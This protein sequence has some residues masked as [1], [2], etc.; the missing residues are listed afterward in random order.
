MRSTLKWVAIGVGGIVAVFALVIAYVAA[1]F[2]PNEYKADIEKT[3]R[4]KTGRTL[5]IKGDIG[6]SIFPSLGMKLGQTS[7]SE[8]NSE[9]EFASVSSAVVSVK[10]LPLLS[11]EVIVDAVQV[12][13]L[14]AAITHDKAGAFNFG[15]LADTKEK[16]EGEADEAMKI[17]IAKIEIVDADVTFADQ[18]AGTR[19][20]LSKL[21]LETGRVANGVTTP[22]DLSATVA[23]DK[24]KAQLDTKLKSK[25][26][27]DVDKKLYR[28]ADLDAS[29]KGNYGGISGMTATAKGN[30]EARLAT[31]EYAADALV[32]NVTG[33]QAG[34][35]MS[36][37]LDAPKLILTQ[38]KVDGGKI[39]AEVKLQE[40]KSRTTAKIT[41]GRVHG[42]FKAFTAGPLDADIEIEGD[43]RTTKAKLA[44]GLSGDLEAKRFELP[45]LSL[46]A[47]VTD[48]K[49]PRGSFDATITGIARADLTKQTG[50]LDF[51][52]KIEQS[53][54][55]GRLGITDFSPLAVTFDLNADELDVDRLLGKTRGKDGKP[56]KDKPAATA[57]KDDKIDLSAL[58]NVNAAGSVKVGKLT[59][60]NLKGSQVRAG[61]KV[62]G[63]RLDVAPLSAQLYQGT[64]N[65]SLSASAADN[66]V[67]AVKQTLAGVSVGPLL[68]DA[69]DIDTLEGKGTVSLDLTTQGATMDALK[70]ALGG[71]ASVNLADGAIK[72]IDI[73]GTIRGARDKVRELRGQQVKASDKTQKTDFSELKASFNVKNGVA[74]NDDL[75]MKSPL[76]RVSGAGDIDIGNDRLNY[77]LK[78]TL[79]ATTQGQGGRD[80]TDLTGLTIPVKLTG[81]LE[82]PD[83]TIDF[84][85]MVTD[86]A[87]Q[88][89]QDEI[90]KRLPGQTKA[91]AAPA[92]G[93]PASSD[94]RDAI[95][96]RLKGILGR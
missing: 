15:D 60:L 69:A 13:G 76:L 38:Q 74:R 37:K 3:V 47:K 75:S 41:L 2:D 7:L 84:A 81:R 8:R 25:L 79:V 11:K 94:P 50:A 78:P 95:R 92:G 5:D 64:L 58:K 77:V 70:K 87:K 19:Y 67:F 17:D 20:R 56:A 6:L 21:N 73:A 28:L 83:Y 10:L 26:T 57:A 31:G 53:N 88:R 1:T 90:L 59:L 68:R 52:G 91:P 61:I 40:A 29:A 80:R 89:I 12:T 34:G 16:P 9:R 46:N 49:L 44:S 51:S 24:D 54:V 96:D 32:L 86:I 72:G 27:F 14:R 42:A 71:T 30:V 39:V 63:G 66:A 82:S 4:Q 65:G 62:A 43:G 18:A 23:S 48:P 22:V 93:A 85:G 36:V 33:K 55:S 35:D 45:K